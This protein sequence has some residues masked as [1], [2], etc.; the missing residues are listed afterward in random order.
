M[1]WDAPGCGGSSDL[2]GDW[3]LGDLADC[4]AAFIDALG[5]APVHLLGLSFGGALAIEVFR[6]HSDAVRSLTLVSAY[7]GWIGS[8][9]YDDARARVAAAERMAVMTDDEFVDGWLGIVTAP[10]SGTE[11]GRIEQFLRETRRRSAPTLSHAMFVDLRSVLP[12]IDVPTLVVHGR[13]DERAPW[14]VASELAVGIAHSEIVVLDA[15]HLVNIDAPGQLAE[16]L[17]SFLD[18]LKS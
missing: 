18:D 8:L 11:R 4:A 9:G 16:V 12:T 3:T 15:G 7:A 2:P 10:T 14:S 1:V 17:R 5:L 6:R 13:N